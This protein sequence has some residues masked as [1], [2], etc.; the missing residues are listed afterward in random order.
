[1][2]KSYVSSI[3]AVVNCGICI[4]CGICQGVCPSGALSF[5]VSN[6]MFR[7][8]I[9]DA[10][11]NNSKGC[12][13]CYDSCPGVGV[14][15]ITLSQEYFD[16]NETKADKYAGR[17]LKCF[18]ACS[19]NESIRLQC[20]SGGLVTQF[21]V[22][23]LETN[24]IDGAVV[25]KYDN[26][27]ALKVKTFI[28][29]TREEIIS[30]K[31]SKYAPVTFNNIVQDIK[32]AKGSRYVIVGLPCHIHGFRKLEKIDKRF[33][34]KIFGYFSL[35]CS[36]SQ[37][38]HYTEYILS[39]CHLDINK[40][41]YLS[42]REGEPS[43]MVARG[44]GIDFFKKYSDYNRPLKSTFY[45][46]RCLFCVDFQGE[47]ADVAF[48]DIMKKPEDDMGNGMNAVI[49]RSSKWLSLFEQATNDG[50]ICSN[51]I[52]L[53]RLN[54]KR[55][56]TTIKKE[57]NGSFIALLSRLGKTVPMYDTNFVGHVNWKI[58]SKYCMKRFKQY[59]GCHKWLWFMLPSMR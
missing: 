54:Y 28:A 59:V 18:A 32:S 7:P 31:G 45:P 53:D 9:D 40:I 50:A 34:E 4:G 2:N 33:R 27:S 12:H 49:V 39:K 19:N 14:N 22:W 36:G 29:S 42:Y 56:M 10:K 37:T 46:R 26:E 44:E 17:Y 3:K 57:Q 6:G 8:K 21:L 25:A 58:F 47:L 24:R 41:N 23:L 16:D 1:M 5:H 43:G 20:A 55:A 11:C 35:F 15:L 13:R 51:E 38:F 30:A 52:S 48:G